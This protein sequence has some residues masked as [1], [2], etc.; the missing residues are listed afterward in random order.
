MWLNLIYPFSL[1]KSTYTDPDP[2]IESLMSFFNRGGSVALD[3]QFG[4]SEFKS[5]S[6][7]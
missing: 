2:Y 6:E 7:R 3:L 1:F 4:G 5:R